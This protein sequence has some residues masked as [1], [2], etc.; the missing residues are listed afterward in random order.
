MRRIALCIAQALLI[1]RTPAVPLPQFSFS[2]RPQTRLCSGLLL[3]QPCNRTIHANSRKLS[4]A[5]QSGERV[6]HHP[7]KS[8]LLA[9][10]LSKRA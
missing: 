9:F 3:H 8:L 6:A 2:F 7:R 1:F 10:A 4:L 5:A